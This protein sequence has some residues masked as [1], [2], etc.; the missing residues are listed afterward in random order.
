MYHRTA[1]SVKKILTGAK[2]ADLPVQQPTQA[3][4]ST[5]LRTARALGITIPDAVLARAERVIE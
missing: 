1:E 3:E 5:N 4:L 2:P